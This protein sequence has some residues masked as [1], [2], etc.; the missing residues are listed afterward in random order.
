METVT[1]GSNA[2]N[3][4]MTPTL[5]V[6]GTTVS[7]T[8]TIT[9]PATSQLAADARRERG[10]RHRRRHHHHERRDPFRE[11]LALAAANGDVILILLPQGAPTAQNVLV[12]T[13]SAGTLNPQVTSSPTA[14]PWTASL[15]T[16]AQG[17]QIKVW[18]ITGGSLAPGQT[19][20]VQ[21]ANIV[22][23]PTP[24]APIIVVTETLKGDQPT[25]GTIN[26]S[27]T[28]AS[29]A[30][31]AN[32][33]P[34]T[35]G[36]GQQ[37]S[38]QWSAIGGS[39]VQIQGPTQIDIP[40]AGP[41]PI[42]SQNTPVTPY[43]TVPQTTF[44]LVVATQDQQ[45]AKYP[46]TVQLSPPIVEQFDYS[47]PGPFG[48]GDAITFEWD[49]DYSTAVYLTPAIPPASGQVQPVG[50]QVVV[51]SKYLPK[52]SNQ[53]TLTFTLTTKGFALSPSQPPPA[54]TQTIQLN[55]AQILYFG[56]SDL[57]TKAV[58]QVVVNG[59][60][61]VS[62]PNGNGLYTLTVTGP[63]GPLT[64]YLGPG[65]Y[66]EVQ[67]FGASPNPSPS[68]GSP[69]TLSWQTLNAVALTLDPGN[70]QIPLTSI[71]SGSYAVTPTVQT[72]Y[73]LTAQAASGQSITSQITVAV[74][75]NPK[76]G[77]R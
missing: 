3:Y 33:V 29:L 20:T 6:A 61:T 10:P 40:L 75:A 14:Q 35:V 24:N 60:A 5:F 77:H 18:P 12:P 8:V 50:S 36:M 17:Y 47:P 49:V 38:L 44:T 25:T 28:S 70:I 32:A 22:V 4:V 19:V 63:G 1:A 39:T 65:P 51:P 56:Y 27:V 72:N 42:Y 37:T 57:T 54:P 62:G 15:T 73:V 11:E 71:A 53:S 74:Q 67:Y 58:K 55:P 46:V 45:T 9:N 52:Q 30:I 7:A 23:T 21:I 59:F 68:P 48:L 64:Q 69:V 76:G 26:S 2:Y 31:V 41:G 66:L 13:Q 16:T 34:V 43:Q